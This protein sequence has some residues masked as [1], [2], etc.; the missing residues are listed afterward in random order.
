MECPNNT[1]NLLIYEHLMDHVTDCDNPQHSVSPSLEKVD[2]LFLGL[3]GHLES[4]TEP[5]L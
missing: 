2:S 3:K 4:D 1:L 5:L